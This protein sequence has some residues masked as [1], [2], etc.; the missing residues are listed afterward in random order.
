MIYILMRRRNVNERESV[1]AE[2]AAVGRDIVQCNQLNWVWYHD[3][4]DVMNNVI[5][6][7]YNTHPKPEMNEMAIMSEKWTHMN[8]GHWHWH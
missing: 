8:Y 5:C 4:E 7:I 3:R 1:A 2:R 6:E